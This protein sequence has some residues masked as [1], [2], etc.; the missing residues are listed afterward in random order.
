MASGFCQTLMVSAKPVALFGA[1]DPPPFGQ[2][3]LFR[4][5]GWL[6]VPFVVLLVIFATLVW[7]LQDLPLY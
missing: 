3:D 4:L 6:I 2:A 5:A 7:P 1:M